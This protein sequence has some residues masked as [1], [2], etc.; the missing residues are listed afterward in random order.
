MNSGRKALSWHRMRDNSNSRQGSVLSIYGDN[1]QRLNN[2]INYDELSNNRIFNEN[3]YILNE[4]DQYW[5][6]TNI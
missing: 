3:R 2:T 6:K 4:E 1:N 5:S